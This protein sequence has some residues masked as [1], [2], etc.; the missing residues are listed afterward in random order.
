VSHAIVVRNDVLTWEPWEVGE[1]GPGQIRI[2]VQAAGIN[3][4][5]LS[6]RA[7]RHPPPP[8]ASPILGLE[9]A[10]VV[11]AV[12]EG[13]TEHA[14]GDTVCALLGGGGYATH[15]LV[16][17]GHAIPLPPGLSVV[18][19]AAVVE[20]W[21]TAWQV[22]MWVGGLSDHPGGAKVVLHA[23]ASGVGTAAIQILRL[24]GHRS[25]VTVGSADK[26]ARCVALGAEGGAVRHDGPWLE[27]VQ[28]WA[29][30]GVDLILD[31]VGANYFGDNLKALARDGAAVHIGLLSGREAEVN[32]GLVL[33]K[34]L[35][36]LGSTLR[37]RPS[38]Y[39]TELMQALKTE[40]WPRFGSGEI[41]PVVHRTF[42]IAQAGEAHELLRSNTTVG[43]LVLTVD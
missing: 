24:W 27:A 7:G 22:L 16:D 26:V 19:A 3:R 14:V 10:G 2:R 43:A 28:A 23:G 38:A 35:R 29:P 18:E 34:R 32:L 1:P 6:Q 8:G 30:D 40:L 42:P 11:D 36:I 17:A 20:V 12:G 25:F 33:V 13:V 21:A 5:D 15:V 31:P 37:A 9:A 39:K 41:T 4:A